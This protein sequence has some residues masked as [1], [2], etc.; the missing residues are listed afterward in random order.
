MASLIKKSNSYIFGES[1]FIEAQILTRIALFAV[2]VSI[3]LLIVNLIGSN[4]PIENQA[5]IALAIYFFI[6]FALLRFIPSIHKQYHYIAFISILLAQIL[7]ASIWINSIGSMGG[8][9]FIYVIF[10]SAHFIFFKKWLLVANSIIT[11][12][13]VIG[14]LY[15]EYVTSTL[16]TF[17]SPVYTVEERYIDVI[18]GFI[19][20]C[21]F[22]L[23]VIYSIKNGHDLLVRRLTH[24]SKA[25]AEDLVL[26]RDL[27]NQVFDYKPEIVDGFD[28]AVQIL[29]SLELGGDLFDLSRPSPDKLRIF[30]ADAQGHGINAALSAML[31]KSK[32]VN[33][34]SNRLEPAE[35]LVKLNTEIINSYRDSL[36]FTAAVCDV[37][38]D[39][40]VFS[41]AGH[42]AQYLIQENKLEI[43]E[44]SG[45]PAGMFENSAFTNTIFKI[46]NHTRLLLFTDALVEE[47][48]A[49]G[50]NGKNW[51][52]NI[53][54]DIKGSSED[55][56]HYLLDKLASKLSQSPQNL[57]LHDDLMI[58]SVQLG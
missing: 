17:S 36:S 41:S 10:I 11:I 2:L 24:K 46:S 8:V 39:K 35:M 13:S 32:W 26:A 29:P 14:L 37:H 15:H 44:N 47:V 58:V 56:N 21:V 52:E 20:A 54:K 40:I 55:F 25:F 5:L 12:S 18:T 43:L 27:Q 38:K 33:I 50:S 31:I 48:D 22:L 49:K 23:F 45:P 7:V 9:I 19:S 28:F 53:L 42:P 30:L 51:L 1:Q 4:R 57:S 16:W 3:V 6:V 34:N